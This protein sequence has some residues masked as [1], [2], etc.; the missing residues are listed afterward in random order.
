MA[1]APAWPGRSACWAG[2]AG[3]G[4]GR[5]LTTPKLLRRLGGGHDPPD[6]VPLFQRADALVVEGHQRRVVTGVERGGLLPHGPL[7]GPPGG[8]LADLDAGEPGAG[9]PGPEVDLPNPFG[10]PLVV[11]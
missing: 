5:V 8:A 7:T 11:R 6:Q 4:S 1:A 3:C 2:S 9:Q 10:Q